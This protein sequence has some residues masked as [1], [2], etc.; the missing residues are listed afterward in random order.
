MRKWGLRIGAF[1]LSLLLGVGVSS[2]RSPQP[3]MSLCDIDANSEEHAGIVRLRVLVSN[4]VFPSSPTASDRVISTYAGCVLRMIPDPQP[5]LI[6]M[7]NRS[8]SS[9]KPFVFSRVSAFGKMGSNTLP[10]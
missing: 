6:W 10:R 3:L 2:V 8:I 1:A 4:D 9:E 5:M 7:R